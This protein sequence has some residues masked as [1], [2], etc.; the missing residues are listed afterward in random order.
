MA[1]SHQIC[2]YSALHITSNYIEL[3]IPTINHWPWKEAIC[4]HIVMCYYIVIHETIAIYMF[5][6]DIK[7]L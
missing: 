4:C 1:A 5:I 7:N 3:A 2:Q 6:D